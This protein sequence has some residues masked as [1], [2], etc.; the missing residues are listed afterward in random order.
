MNGPHLRELVR[1]VGAR[2]TVELRRV[3]RCGG[4]ARAVPGSRTV[5]VNSR[6]VEPGADAR[7][8]FGLK[9]RLY[10][11]PAGLRGSPLDEWL[12]AALTGQPA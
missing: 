1:S 8:D 4:A 3:E 9:C 11:T 6:D 7:T 12:L 2:E 5:R 10:Q